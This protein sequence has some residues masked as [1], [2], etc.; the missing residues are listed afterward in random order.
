MDP[1][2]FAEKYAQL[3]PKL[4]EVL[5][6]VLQGIPDAEIAQDMGIQAATVRKHIERIYRVFDLNSDFPQDRRSR[7]SDLCPLCPT[8]GRNAH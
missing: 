3:T 4:H 7:R 2:E 5:T 1:Q 6:Q 8:Q